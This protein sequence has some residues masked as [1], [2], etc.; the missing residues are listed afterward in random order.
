MDAEIIA[1]GSELLTPER[2]DTNSLWLTAQLNELGIEVVAKMV[3]GDDRARLAAAVRAVWERSPLLVVTGGLGPTEDDVTREAVAQALGRQLVFHPEILAVIEERFHRA[4]RVMAGIN[5]RQAYL[6]EGA[7]AL[8]NRVGT[9][10]GQ[11][12]READRAVLLLPGPPGE[13]KPMFS[14]SALPRLRAIAPPLVIRTLSFRVAGIAESDL[15]D[16][17]SPVYKRYAG[18]ATTVLAAPGDIQIHLRARCEDE[19]RAEALVGEIG[20]Q[21]QTILG[22]RIYSNSDPMEVVI[23]KLLA[24]RSATLAVAESC[25]GGLLAQRITSVPG[26]SAYFLGGLLVYHDAMKTGLAGVSPDLVREHGAVSEAVAR[27]LAEGTRAR[28]SATYALAVTGVAGPSGGTDSA[29][30]GTVFIGLAGPEGVVVR[31][32]RFLGDRE[33]VRAFA[34]Q[35]A[36]DMLRRRLL[37]LPEVPGVAPA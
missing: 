31:R 27:A 16:R 26:S 10:P 24:A 6:I 25:T 22:D 20:R 23:G 15:D 19:A 30:V 12:I 2:L 7:E 18:V 28:T 33:R 36:M 21:I 17:I 8:P 3:V 37:G 29:P 4:G 13:L 1:V 35:T 11:W 14:E 34:A 9:A 32:F 5:R